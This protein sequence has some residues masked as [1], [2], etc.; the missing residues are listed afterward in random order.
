MLSWSDGCGHAGPLERVAAG[1]SSLLASA[2]AARHATSHTTKG[3]AATAAL[4][5]ETT[6]SSASTSHA[7]AEHLH[8]DLGVDT[9]AHSSHATHTAAA[10]EHVRR[11]N[12]ISARVVSLTFPA[13]VLV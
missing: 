3:V 4:E 11:I 2:T 5:V 7:T 8:K 12:Q 10:A 9:A 1:E 6:T 13:I